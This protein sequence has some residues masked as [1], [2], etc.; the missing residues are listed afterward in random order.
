MFPL[1]FVRDLKSNVKKLKK[2]L[3][4]NHLFCLYYYYYYICNVIIRQTYLKPKTK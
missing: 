1:F 4:V 3:K 2:R